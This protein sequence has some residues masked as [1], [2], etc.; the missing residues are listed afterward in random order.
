MTLKD[1]R[2]VEELRLNIV[3]IGRLDANGYRCTIGDGCYR[4]TKGNMVIAWGDAKDHLY[5]L[6]TK[7]PRERVQSLDDE[8]EDS[9][10]GS[11]SMGESSEARH[12]DR[13]A[14]TEAA[15]WH[16]RLGH[17]SEKGLT[18]LMRDGALTDMKDAHLDKC[19]D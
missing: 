18:Y 13:G 16:R 15:L 9:E 7:P 17:M 5:R 1:V 10:D 14:S 8:D 3:S 4:I 12:S 19:E 2:H 6:K 11:S